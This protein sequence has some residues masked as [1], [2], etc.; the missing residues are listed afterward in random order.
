MHYEQ[1]KKIRC[2]RRRCSGGF[3]ESLELGREAV[4]EEEAIEIPA[5]EYVYRRRRR[6]AREAASKCGDFYGGRRECMIGPS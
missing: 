5:G 6:S 4:A 3:E 1:D 2:V